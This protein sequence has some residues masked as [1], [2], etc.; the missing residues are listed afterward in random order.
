LAR[1]KGFEKLTN[2]DGAL[3]MFFKTLKPKT[4]SS[5][6]VAVADG[7]GRTTAETVVAPMELPQFNR[8]AVDGYEV[9]AEDTAEASQFKPRNLRLTSGSS[10]GGG[11]AK[12]IWTGNPLSRGSDAVIM[13]E[14][15]RATNNAIEIIASVTP[16]ENVSKK[17]EDIK[18]DEVA[19]KAG[20]RLQPPHLALLS[21]LG[22]ARVNVVRK[23]KVA[24]LS[25][26]NELVELG[27]KVSA[28]KIV[29][30]N[31]FLIAG[32]V[33]ELGAEPVYMGIVKDAEDAIESRIR[34]ALDKADVVITT[35]GTSVGAADFVPIVVG[36]LGKPGI[37]VHGVALR[38]GMPTALGVIE[39]KPI[40][41]LSGYPVAAAV[42]FEVFARPILLKL[43]GLEHEVRPWVEARLGRRVA[44]ALGRRVYLRVR[45]ARRKDRLVAEPIV[46]RGSG[47]L[48]SLTKADGYVIIPEGREGL[49][50]GETVTVHLFNSIFRGEK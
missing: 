38:P 45:V 4:L 21:A 34:Q 13:L 16:G 25:T 1:L 7:L 36:K 35:G 44:G 48:S 24:I 50:E 39:D 6:T 2:V 5:E 19:V 27:E 40:F 23:P 9:R 47:L 33:G 31:R 30:S 32:L 28:N 12:Q 11:Q 26:G 18:K 17:G 10:L 43:L 15:T 8:S 42:G 41:V 37:V 14:H 22:M 3:T 29:N 46:T 20:I 49:E